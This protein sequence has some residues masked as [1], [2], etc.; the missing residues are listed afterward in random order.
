MKTFRY[1]A[2]ACVAMMVS[3]CGL[4]KSLSNVETNAPQEVFEVVEK[5]P[6]FPGGKE[7]LKDWVKGHIYY[8]PEALKRGIQ[9]RVIATFVINEQGKVVEP[10]IIQSVHPLL[11][12]E[13]VRMIKRMPK[14]KPAEEKGVPVRVKYTMPVPFVTR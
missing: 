6:E 7:A 10:T 1:L 13:V 14:W 4:Q 11:D 12:R 3:A 8:N 5:M 9:G 2:L